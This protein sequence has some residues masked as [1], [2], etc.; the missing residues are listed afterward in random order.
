MRWSKLGGRKI[1][2]VRDGRCLGDLADVDL[3]FDENGRILSLLVR[4]S[5][6]RGWKRKNVGIPWKAVSRIGADVCLVDRQLIQSVSHGGDGGGDGKG[7]DP[8]TGAQSG[9]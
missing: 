8:F 3:V 1:I 6:R 2:D 7:G 5:G 4:E 9:A